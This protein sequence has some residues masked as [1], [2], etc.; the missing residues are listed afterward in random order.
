MIIFSIQSIYFRFLKYFLLYHFYS[1]Q[2]DRSIQYMLGHWPSL[3]MPP[4]FHLDLIKIIIFIF[5]INKVVECIDGG[6]HIP[7]VLI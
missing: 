2:I 5:S 6:V 4:I 1:I 3:V 7:V